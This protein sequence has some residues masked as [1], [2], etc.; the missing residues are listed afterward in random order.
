MTNT[1]ARIYIGLTTL[2]MGLV[3]APSAIAA[4]SAVD[5]YSGSGG[6]SLAGVSGGASGSSTATDPGSL[7]FTGLDVGLLIGGGLLLVLIGVGMARLARRV[8]QS[9]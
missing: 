7:P 9:S 3:A 8:P 1:K 6:A 2:V 5:T 4:G